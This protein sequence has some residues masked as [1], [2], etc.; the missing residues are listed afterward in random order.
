MSDMFYNE[1]L[2]K[3]EL[4]L[5]KEWKRLYIAMLIQERPTV[6]LWTRRLKLGKFIGE[7]GKFKTDRFQS[8]LLSEYKE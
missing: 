5:Y 6:H 3:E 2:T 4:P 1:P 7:H 8:I